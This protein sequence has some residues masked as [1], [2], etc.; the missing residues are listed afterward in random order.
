MQ[1]PGRQQLLQVITHQ[2]LL[3]ELEQPKQLQLVGH[4]EQLEVGPPAHP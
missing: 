1:R 4:P 2:E 3:L